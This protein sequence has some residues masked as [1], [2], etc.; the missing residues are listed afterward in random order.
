M[1]QIHKTII[2]ATSIS[3][4]THV[5]TFVCDSVGVFKKSFLTGQM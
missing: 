2:Q 1:L 4:Q 5:Q 3:V